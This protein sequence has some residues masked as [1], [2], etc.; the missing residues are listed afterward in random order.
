MSFHEMI[1]QLDT[2]MIFAC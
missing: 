1:Y 2:Y